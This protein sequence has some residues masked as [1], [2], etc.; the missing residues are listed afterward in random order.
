MANH[1]TELV[2]KEV[3]IK[4]GNQILT[5]AYMTPNNV[6]FHGLNYL[7]KLM[8]W[9]YEIDTNNTTAALKPRDIRR[10]WDVWNFHKLDMELGHKN[11]DAPGTVMEMT[12]AV[13]LPHPEE[14]RRYK[15]M[16]IQRVASAIHQHCHVCM[17]VDSADG[18]EIY[19]LSDYKDIV[20]SQ[21]ITEEVFKFVVGTGQPDGNGGYDTGAALPAL[22]EL[23]REE[24]SGDLD[25]IRFNERS[26]GATDSG[27][28]DAPDL[29][30]GGA[31]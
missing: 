26:S 4:G 23:G 6:L 13:L 7:G 12:R 8:R 21:N 31:Q 10:M 18:H 27:L 9:L 16:K 22:V 17:S 19:Q 24:P 2:V 28:P 25:L 15:N 1:V 3:K 20:E 5:A 11:F 30:P 29:P 14:L